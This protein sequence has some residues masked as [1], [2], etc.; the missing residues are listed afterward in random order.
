MAEIVVGV[1]GASGIVLAH[2]SIDV[3]TRM[4]HKVHLVLSK[5]SLY[6]AVEE[7]GAIYGTVQKFVN[8]FSSEQRELIRLHAIGDFSSPLASGSYPTDGMIVIP[9][10][11]A[12]LAAI[13]IGLSDNVLRRAADVH[14]K[15]RRP[16]IIVPREMPLAENHLENMLRI[17][18]MGGMICPPIPGW[19]TK[20][21]TLQDMEDFIVGRIL[22]GL[23]IDAK[24]YPRWGQTATSSD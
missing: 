12:T 8:S 24:L 6:T 11:M 20:P 13:A 23:K 18:R 17:A 1:S 21:K 16:L 9:C 10:S 14:L 2:R 7:M 4:Q 19:Y 15:E 5:A 22:D 3:L